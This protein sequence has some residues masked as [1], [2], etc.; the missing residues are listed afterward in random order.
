MSKNG[1][2]YQFWSF[3]GILPPT[4]GLVA[5]WILIAT[6]KFLHIY[7]FEVQRQRFGPLLFWISKKKFSWPALIYISHLIRH[8]RL[9][10]WNFAHVI[11]VKFEGKF[12]V[13]GQIL[14]IRAWYMYRA[15]I[16]EICPPLKINRLHSCILCCFINSSS[17]WC[18]RIPFSRVYNK[19]YG[20][21]SNLCGYYIR[22]F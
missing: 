20:Y 2:R 19:C 14:R 3:W 13:S 22:Y 5:S 6:Q 10:T 7:W 16:H 18:R 15:L 4:Y 21:C 1:E 11:Y 12:H 8:I 9:D 17:R